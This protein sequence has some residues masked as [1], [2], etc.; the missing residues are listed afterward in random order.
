MLLAVVGIGVGLA[1]GF[2]LR[3]SLRRVAEVRIRWWPL[4]FLGLAMQAL[5][6]P[7][8]DGDVD[9]WIGAGLLAGSYAVL[10]VVVA[11]N[12]RLP[13]APV[14]MLGFALNALVISLNMGM[15][16]GDGAIKAAAGDRYE[17]A[18]RVLREGDDPKHHLAGPGDVLVQLADVIPVGPPIKQIL[19]VGDV[20]ASVGTAWL[21]AGLMLGS[22]RSPRSAPTPAPE[23]TPGRK[24]P[25]EEL[26]RTARSGDPRQAAVEAASS[27]PL[28]GSVQPGDHSASS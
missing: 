4:A 3:G 21:A 6:I 20:F 8:M 5:P 22:G 16:V 10:L 9:R 1:V 18:V 12:I 15:P 14:L 28:E 7:S 17:H 2:A 23:E 27:D 11:M 13:G 24:T 25:L 19:S 26:D